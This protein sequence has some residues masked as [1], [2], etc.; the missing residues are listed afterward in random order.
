MIEVDRVGSTLRKKS[1]PKLETESGNNVLNGVG[2]QSPP[3]P[4]RVY[5]SNQTKPHHQHTAKPMKTKI[6][7]PF[8]YAPSKFSGLRYQH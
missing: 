5:V 6:Y 1:T 7:A 8:L 2:G 4:H 3:N